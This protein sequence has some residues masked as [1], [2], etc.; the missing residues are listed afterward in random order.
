[1]PKAEVKESATMTV[2]ECAR[3]IGVSRESAYKAVHDGTLPVLRI[4]QRFLIPR[5]A[6][7]RLLAGETVTSEPAS[8][9]S[10]PPSLTCAKCGRECKTKAGL[11]AH[12][13]THYRRTPTKR[14]K[15]A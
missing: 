10:L 4:G 2:E 3:Y 15:R 12:I 11:E 1:M 14:E 9:E 6:L 8:A 13:G 5:A 7:D